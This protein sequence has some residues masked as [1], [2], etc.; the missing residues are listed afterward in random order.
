MAAYIKYFTTFLVQSYFKESLLISIGILEPIKI[1]MRNSELTKLMADL[2]YVKI[3]K[4]CLT[5]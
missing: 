1:E 3:Q 4:N 2:D 5:K